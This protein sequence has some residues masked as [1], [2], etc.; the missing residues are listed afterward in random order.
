MNQSLTPP[1]RVKTLSPITV[2]STLYT[3]EKK[4]KTYYYSPQE[5]GSSTQIIN[6]LAKK[7][8]AFHGGKVEIPEPKG[9]TVRSVYVTNRHL[10]IINY[11]G[12]IIK[13]WR[14]IYELDLPEPYLSMALDAGL[15]AKNSQG[16][17]M[18]EVVN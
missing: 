2:Y 17:G 7:L 1:V 8:E 9:A 11:K 5:P 15:G 6:N 4:R 14:G 3:P 16:F 18:V 13:G 12:T 10:S